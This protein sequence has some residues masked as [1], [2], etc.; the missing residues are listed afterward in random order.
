MRAGFH[1]SNCWLCK[2][3]AA[4]GT[5]ATDRAHAARRRA[6]GRRRHGRSALAAQHH[7]VSLTVEGLMSGITITGRLARV[8]QFAFEAAVV[9]LKIFERAAELFQQHPCRCSI[10]AVT[11]QPF[12]QDTLA[13]NDCMALPDMKR[14]LGECRQPMILLLHK[15]DDPGR[16]RVGALTA[17]FGQGRLLGRNNAP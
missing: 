16:S 8:L 13:S 5:R 12:Y 4:P 1:Q 17:R 9:L 10:A 2:C 3:L 6:S 7:C 15:Q 14:G 11:F